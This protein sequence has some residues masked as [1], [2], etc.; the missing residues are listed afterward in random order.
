M[1]RILTGLVFLFTSIVAIAQESFPINGIRDI[2]AGDFFM[3]R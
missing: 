1:K 3:K 2:P